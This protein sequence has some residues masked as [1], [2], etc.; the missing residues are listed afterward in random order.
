MLLLL[1]RLSRLLHRW[2]RRG[3]LVCGR[4][5]GA[6]L[7]PLWPA[8]VG[9]DRRPLLLGLRLRRRRRRLWGRH[10]RWAPAHEAL[11]LGARKVVDVVVRG[12]EA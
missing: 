11:L 5:R 2:R 6:E 7:L 10:R 1:K 9:V 3:L 4:G 12:S 8:G